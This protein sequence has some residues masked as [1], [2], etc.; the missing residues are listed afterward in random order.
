MVS[1][2][3]SNRARFINIRFEYRT[4]D[5]RTRRI[6]EMLRRNARTP[7]SKIARALGITEAAVRKRIRRLEEEGVILGYRAVIDYRK[8]GMVCSFTGVDVEPEALM[9]TIRAVR[10]LR[11][12]VALYLTTGDHDLVAEIVCGS[13][14]ELDEIHRRI[15]SLEG[16]RRVCPAI[17]TEVLKLE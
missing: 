2:R 11:G 9:E 6:V 17:V 12:V 13:L 14:A 5:E 15:A 4:M 10:G 1:P 16:V 3:A 7:K 8:L